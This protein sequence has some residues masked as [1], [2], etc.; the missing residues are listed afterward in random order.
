MTIC[1]WHYNWFI[2]SVLRKE[3]GMNWWSLFLFWFGLFGFS[4]CFF[5]NFDLLGL[6]LFHDETAAR[7]YAPCLRLHPKTAV[8]FFFWC[9]VKMKKKT[10]YHP[11]NNNWNRKTSEYLKKNKIHITVLRQKKSNETNCAHF[12]S[13][14]KH[15]QLIWIKLKHWICYVFF[16]FI[17]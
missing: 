15:T 10:S 9:F 16:Y 17:L 1:K 4:G 6:S 12:T 2:Y 14:K 11:C 7:Q 13:I 3:K 8:N 5:L